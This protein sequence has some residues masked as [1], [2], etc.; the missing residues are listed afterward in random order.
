MAYGHLLFVDLDEGTH[1]FDQLQIT[2]PNVI[3]HGI[4]CEGLLRVLSW[5][6]FDLPDH[7]KRTLDTLLQAAGERCIL[8]PLKVRMFE[9]M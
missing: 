6:S 9:I 2:H 5:V 8:W 4:R 7:F 1:R 3:P